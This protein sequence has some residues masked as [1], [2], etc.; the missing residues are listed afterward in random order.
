MDGCEETIKLMVESLYSLFKPL[1][2]HRQSNRKIFIIE[3]SAIILYYSR[4]FLISL[5]LT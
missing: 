5:L 4:R 3:I 1:T 2:H